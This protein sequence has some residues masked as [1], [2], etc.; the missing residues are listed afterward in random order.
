[1]LLLMLDN[2]ENIL[3][4]IVKK[5]KPNIVLLDLSLKN[6][7]SLN[8]VKLIR[9]NFQNIKIIIMDLLPL[10]QPDVLE[11]VQGGDRDSY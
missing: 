3:T 11:F 9:K 7:S 5:L 2:G 4:F 1:M 10:V 8:V 6:Q